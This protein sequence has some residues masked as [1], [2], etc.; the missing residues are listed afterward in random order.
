MRDLP[1]GIQTC[2]YLIFRLIGLQTGA[3]VRTSRG[4]IDALIEMDEGVFIFKVKLDDTA[5]AALEQIAARGY[6]QPH[7]QRGKPIYC[8][9]VA[10]GTQQRAITE[11]LVEQIG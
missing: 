3:E 6:A 4:R 11:W 5:Q 10:L 9:G 2:S 8:L 1:I 7:C